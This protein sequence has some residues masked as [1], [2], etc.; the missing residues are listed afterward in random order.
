MEEEIE[1][2]NTEDSFKF[3]CSFVIHCTSSGIG[4]EWVGSIIVN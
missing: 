2:L 4:A 3:L 1:K